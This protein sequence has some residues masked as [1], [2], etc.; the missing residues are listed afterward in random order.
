MISTRKKLFRISSV[1][2]ST[3]RIRNFY[4]ALY[5]KHGPQNWWPAR[6]RLECATGAILTQNTSW[7]NAEKAIER[8]RG[9]SMLSAGKLRAVSHKQ[10]ALLIRPCGY[11]NLKARRLKNFIDFLFADYAGAM[12]N[13]L[14]EDTD[15]L[16]KKLLS[17]NGIGEETA[18]SILLYALGKPVFVVDNYS[19]RILLRHRLIPEG[20]SYTSIQKLFAESLA[21]DTEVFG[22]YHALIVKTGK[23]HCRKTANCEGCPLEG[24]PHDRGINSF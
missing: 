12:E 18:D 13:M 9:C 7:K 16:R 10:L 4:S 22:E 11:H 3:K 2:G 21:A 19:R 17:V 8:L 20:A 15:I 24:D 1:T 5:R 14:T 6:T 23:L